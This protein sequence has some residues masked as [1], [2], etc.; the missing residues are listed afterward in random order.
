MKLSDE[1]TFLIDQCIKEIIAH[2][3][4]KAESVITDIHFQP[5]CTSGEL[6]VF[7][8]EDEE[9]AHVMIE[10]WNGVDAASAMPEIEALLCRQI[11][12]HR[13][14]LESLSILKPYSLVLVDMDKETIKDL[15]LVD[16]DLVLASN[17]LM[18]GLDQELD[19]FLRQLLAEE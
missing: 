6:V 15:L 14:E 13:K 2:Y 18:E 11:E 9:L 5:S 17:G 19:E 1:S 3:A 8:D 4:G 10:E 12:L 7:N 16:E